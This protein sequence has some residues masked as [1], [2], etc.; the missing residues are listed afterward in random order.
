MATFL[1][2]LWEVT[3]ADRMSHP[4]IDDSEIVF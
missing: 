2:L 4:I 3:K 1:I